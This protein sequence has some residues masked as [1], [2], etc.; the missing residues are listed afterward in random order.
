MTASNGALKTE[1]E[2]WFSAPSTEL[3]PLFQKALKLTEQHFSRHVTLYTPG[4]RFPAISVTGRN[5]EL[6]CQH[7]G[8]HFLKQMKSIT[9]PK[10]LVAFCHQ[11]EQNH[12]KGCLISGGCTTEGQ[13]PLKPFLPAFAEIKR[14]TNLILNVHTGL[15]TSS[16]AQAL[17]KT[18]IDCASI[19]VVGDN[20][21]L[22]QVYG[23]INQS[24]QDYARTLE[25]L[26]NSRIPVAPH[27]CVGLHHGR[28]LGE[29]AALQLISSTIQPASI[30]I[31]ALMPTKGTRMESV[32][33]P[34]NLD[35][36]RVC[37]LTR[38]I[39]PRCKISLG[40]MR[41]RGMARHQMEKLAVRAGINRLVLPT[42]TTVEY[43][44]RNLYTTQVEEACCI[45]P[46]T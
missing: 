31:I 27:I 28:L 46:T 4:P 14:S 3:A 39:F 44:K 12:G 19:D 9:Q 34:S 26:K 43:L 17:G 22:H 15:L 35:I 45:V 1:L 38:L 16:E 30:V 41:P 25:A 13:L 29:L 18:G 36:A 11:L 10:K 2:Y 6:N 40:C 32:S 24:T 8:G 5:C 21:T 37:A 33:P 42:N 20:G 23:L 7:C